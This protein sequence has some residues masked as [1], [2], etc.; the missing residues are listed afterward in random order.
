MCTYDARV[1]AANAVPSHR[2][3]MSGGRELGRDSRRE[4]SSSDP[5]AFHMEVERQGA[6]VRPRVVFDGAPAA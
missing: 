5:P 6:G 3:D 1:V 2:V 4:R